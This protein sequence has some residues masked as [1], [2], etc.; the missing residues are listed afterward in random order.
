[1]SSPPV[2]CWNFPA[3]TDSQQFKFISVVLGFQ[4]D[5]LIDPVSSLHFNQLTNYRTESAEGSPIAIQV[6]EVNHRLRASCLRPLHP[7]P[8]GGSTHMALSEEQGP[9]TGSLRAKD[10]L[11][12]PCP[13]RLPAPGESALRVKNGAFFPW[14]EAQDTGE[15]TS[16]DTGRCHLGSP[17][18][19]ECLL[20]L[21]PGRPRAQLMQKARGLWGSYLVGFLSLFPRIFE[22]T[23]LK[24]L[25]L[26]LG[27]TF[28]VLL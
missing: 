11:G 6:L 28:L 12:S 10:T 26:D 15:E 19:C 27:N 23:E 17:G 14:K 3:N 9:G 25:T 20:E 22:S 24:W 4:E 2:C 1:M 16:P 8:S 18:P 7:R 5:D 13:G 21:M